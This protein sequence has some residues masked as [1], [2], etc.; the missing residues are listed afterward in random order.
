MALDTYPMKVRTS[1]LLVLGLLGGWKGPALADSVPEARGTETLARAAPALN[2]PEGDVGR[3]VVDP[4]SVQLEGPNAVQSLLVHGQTAK[5]GPIDLT[6]SV[7]YRSRNSEVATVSATGV[8]RGVSDGST[9]VDVELPGGAVAEAKVRVRAARRPRHFHF[10][11]D[12]V[13]ILSKLG[14]NASG[15]HGKAEGQ[16]GFKLS[17][18][19]MTQRPTMP[20]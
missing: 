16:N 13:P 8:V 14:C 7:Q 18:L 5:A 17:S 1:A 11:N 12:I 19:G 20:R 15:C 9:V 2:H 6:R 10:E 3:V 4:E